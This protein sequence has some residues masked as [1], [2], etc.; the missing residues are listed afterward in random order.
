M[1]RLLVLAWVG[2]ACVI[3][4]VPAGTASAHA[5]LLGTSP[6]AGSVVQRFSRVVLRFDEPVS[7]TPAGIELTGPSGGRVDTGRAHAVGATVRVTVQVSGP[8]PPGTYR[9]GWRVVSDDGHPEAGTFTFSVR[10]ATPAP[11][12]PATASASLPAAYALVRWVGYAGFCA[13]A[14]GIAFLLLC[15]PGAGSLRRVRV[16]SGGGG[17]LAWLATWASLPLQG[18]YD[19]GAWSHLLRGDALLATLESRIGAALMARLLL[20]LVLGALL[21]VA[22]RWGTRL[23]PTVRPRLLGAFGVVLLL[24]AAT[25]SLTGHPAVGGD[26]PLA[27]AA[28]AVHLAAVSLWAG[29]LLLVLATRPPLPAVAAFSRMALPCV[30]AIA[31]TGAYAAQR[32][33]SSWASLADTDYGR[34]VL[35]KA[36]GLLLLAGSGLLARRALARAR[37]AVATPARLRAIVAVEVVVALAVLGVAAVLVQTP[38][39]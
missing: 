19:D 35:A 32:Q 5:A 9:V 11:L 23:L 25:W 38:P 16:L 36:T 6:A 3:A 10:R 21:A 37:P 39:R 27:V 30:V 28:D 4:L 12:A 7:V 8:P 31:A 1:R 22:L 29:G 2:L 18:A 33:L 13:L 26:W 14:G 17:L 20:L 15:W 34:L 24:A